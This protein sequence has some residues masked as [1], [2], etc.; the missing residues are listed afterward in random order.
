MAVWQY[1]VYLIPR[2]KLE[3]LYDE[4]PD[5]LDTEIFEEVEWGKA[6]Y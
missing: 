4:I 2:T 3:D 1:D 5:H 6:A